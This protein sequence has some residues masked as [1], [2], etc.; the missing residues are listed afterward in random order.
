M[1]RNLAKLLIANLIAV[2]LVAFAPAALV[3][4]AAATSGFQSTM[5]LQFWVTF[6]NNLTGN[7]SPKLYLSGAQNA[8]VTITWPDATT[9]QET[10]TA[11]AVTTVDANAKINTANKYTS[12]TDGISQTAVKIVADKPISVYLLNQRTASSD[13]SQ[14]YPTE[15]QGFDYRVLTAGNTSLDRRFSVIANEAGT[16]TITVTPKVTL[17]SRTAGVDYT[18]SLT[19]GDV[20]S[21]VGDVTGTR[22]RSDKKITVSSTNGCAVLI[23]GACDH[24]TEFVPPITTWG[25]AFV[26]PASLNTSTTARDLYRV[27]ASQDNTSI[28]I[29]GVSQTLALAGDFYEA[30]IATAG[31]NLV[32]TADKPVLVMQ[33]VMYGSYTDGVTTQTGDPSMVFITP[34]VQYLNDLVITTPATGFAVNAVSLVV[35]TSDVGTA[36]LNG[37]AIP[38]GD[39]SS[40]LTVGSATFQVV[41]K[42]LALGTHTISSTNGVGVFVY[43]FNSYDS[44]AYGAAAGMVDLVQN[45]GGVAQ[46]GYVAAAQINNPNPPQQQAPAQVVAPPAA[47]IFFNR[48]IQAGTTGTIRLSGVNLTGLTS[49]KIGDKTVEIVSSGDGFAEIKLPELAAGVYNF[50][51]TGTRTEGAWIGTQQLVL[52]VAAAAANPNPGGLKSA[53]FTITNFVGGSAVLTAAMKARIAAE[54]AKHGGVK[55]SACV[56]ATSGPTVLRV[57]ASLAQR[58]AVAV[59]RYIATLTPEVIT[60]TTGKNTTVLGGNARK[61]TVTLRF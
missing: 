30:Q 54:V 61:V 23:G 16:T 27:M 48:T 2:T 6:D 35:P 52:T 17:G 53:T 25:K 58:R 40:T 57:D 29:N 31:L 4:P 20:Y 55:S 50:F 41:K 33:A 1:V 22:I 13:A 38:A 5:G 56:G 34:V 26:V 39:Y 7:R 14:A 24:M 10:V 11:G 51:T 15:Y 28:S 37:T 59:C 46:V 47:P 43:G 32:V 19:Q 60:T 45:P 12:S 42:T 36:T 3:Q 49:L 18:V 8:A 21:I 44:Y 9:Q